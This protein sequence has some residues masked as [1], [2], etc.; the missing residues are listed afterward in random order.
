MRNNLCSYTCKSCINTVE[1][2]QCFMVCMVHTTLCN[3]D[4]WFHCLQLKPWGSQ[5]L[6]L[7]STLVDLTQDESTSVVPIRCEV[8]ITLCM[9]ITWDSSN[10]LLIYIIY[11]SLEG[12]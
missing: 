8:L 7:L 1:E 2:R 10:E 4:M 3:S 6:I 11:F 12:Q 5:T 9:N